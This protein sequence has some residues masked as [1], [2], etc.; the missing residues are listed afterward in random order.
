MGQKGTTEQDCAPPGWGGQADQDTTPCYQASP[1]CNWLYPYSYHIWRTC[2][3]CPSSEIG[4]APA[5]TETPKEKNVLVSFSQFLLSFRSL[6][7][8]CCDQFLHYWFGLCLVANHSCRVYVYV[9]AL[10][11]A[12]FVF[13]CLFEVAHCF[14]LTTGCREQAFQPQEAWRKEA[15]E[16]AEDSQRSHCASACHCRS[17]LPLDLTSNTCAHWRFLLCQLQCFLMDCEPFEGQVLVAARPL[18]YDSQC[19]PQFRERI[20]LLWEHRF[21]KLRNGCLLGPMAN[22]G[23]VQ[24]SAGRAGRVVLSYKWWSRSSHSCIAAKNS[25]RAWMGLPPLLQLWCLQCSY[26]LQLLEIQGGQVTSYEVVAVAQKIR[27]VDRGAWRCGWCG[28]CAGLERCQRWVVAAPSAPHLHRHPIGLHQGEW[29]RETNLEGACYISND[30][31]WWEWWQ[32]QHEECK[33]ADTTS[34]REYQKQ[35]PCGHCCL[36]SA[37]QYFP[38]FWL[39][40]FLLLHSVQ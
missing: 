35:S 34:P 24:D 15:Q 22:R 20:W 32:P 26:S 29:S 14:A 4:R 8:V 9:K 10:P 37:F 16:E 25:R 1:C 6:V 19:W 17:S 11:V 23:M 18:A 38:V 31:Q 40:I 13:Q 27:E 12:I 7:S 2:S 33:R 5:G 21:D 36:P 39:P 3:I 30:G 28:W